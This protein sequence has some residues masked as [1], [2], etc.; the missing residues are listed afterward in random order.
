MK[1]I[2]TISFL[3]SI[4]FINA[5]PGTIDPTF[6][7]TDNG[8]GV[9]IGADQY[10]YK[11]AIQQDGKILINGGF[12]TFNGIL[13]KGI[14]RLNTDG[15]LDNSFSINELT[16]SI[17]TAFIQADGKII[18]GGSFTSINNTPRKNIARLNTDGTL[19]TS[20]DPGTGANNLQWDYSK[21]NCPLKY[22]R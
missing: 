10:I 4:L 12:T 15:T 22:R 21:P 20:F 13:Q 14:S 1:K 5:Q 17:T 7:P 18:I 6:N 3:F 2:I 11:M 9:G 16:G 19:D 8:S